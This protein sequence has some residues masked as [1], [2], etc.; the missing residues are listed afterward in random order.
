MKQAADLEKK[1]GPQ[2]RSTMNDYLES[3]REIERRTQRMA[4]EGAE[5]DVQIPSAPAGIPYSYE[6]HVKLMYDL[7]LLAYQANVT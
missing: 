3:V 2:D 7:M 1:L 6:D 5:L 4:L